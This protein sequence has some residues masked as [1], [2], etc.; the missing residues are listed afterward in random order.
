MAARPLLF[1][2]EANGAVHIS[3][4]IRFDSNG[5]SENFHINKISSID[6]QGETLLSLRF[7]PSCTRLLTYQVFLTGHGSGAHTVVYDI[8]NGVQAWSAQYRYCDINEPS[9][10]VVGEDSCVYDA[11]NGDKLTQFDAKA[12][13]S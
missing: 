3:R 4:L 1:A 11:L 7:D 12:G 13:V 9:T 8:T 10:L 5:S 2:W 6:L